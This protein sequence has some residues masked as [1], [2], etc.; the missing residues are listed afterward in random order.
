MHEQT[1][2]TGT[3]ACVA[4]SAPLG[5]T[6]DT[7]KRTPSH[8]VFDHNQVGGILQFATLLIYPIEHSLIRQPTKGIACRM[9]ICNYHVLSFPLPNGLAVL[10]SGCL[11]I[12]D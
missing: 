3:F 11:H 5:R 7:G 4:T 1:R 6:P 10:D 2:T 8:W 12:T 9:A